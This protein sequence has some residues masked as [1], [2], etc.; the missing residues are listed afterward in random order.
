[1]IDR[2]I[3]HVYI[4]VQT[5]RRGQAETADYFGR[6]RLESSYTWADVLALDPAFSVGR[7][8]V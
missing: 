7:D 8:T 5:L 4:T 2:V 1:M 3:H 6:I